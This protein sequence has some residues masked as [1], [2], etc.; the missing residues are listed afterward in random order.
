MAKK[1]KLSNVLA[2]E[3][4]LPHQARAVIEERL[5]SAILDGRLPLVLRFANKSS[6]PCTAL[7][8]CP[9]AKPCASSKR[10]PC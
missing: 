1:I 5:R 8:A 10:S 2:S 6:P 4:L 3:Q 9:C 7:A